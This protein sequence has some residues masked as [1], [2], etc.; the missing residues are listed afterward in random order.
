MLAVECLR[1]A[2]GVGSP[3]KFFDT[4]S[5]DGVDIEIR[6][7]DH[8]VGLGEVKADLDPQRQ[9]LLAE[10]RKRK[11]YLVVLP[12][13]SGSWTVK[14]LP[15]AKIRDLRGTLSSIICELN[16]HQ[17]TELTVNECGDDEHLKVENPL[18]RAGIE[19]QLKG[20]GSRDSAFIQLPGLGGPSPEGGPSIRSWL[21]TVFESHRG[22]LSLRNLEE[23]DVSEKHF[24]VWIGD[25]SPV[26]LQMIALFHPESPPLDEPNLPDWITH[27]W[28]GIPGSSNEDQFLWHHTKTQ[29]WRV[30]RQDSIR[31]S[32]SN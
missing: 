20:D 23:A 25:N 17:Q 30:L 11:L 31:N 22:K 8:L 1:R 2:Y 10:M 29:G 27:I 9:G 15:G 18:Q 6:S 24:F 5:G 14:L 19:F 28:V 4:G 12:P 7:S 16:S 32:K 13:G 26:E 3:F 21:G